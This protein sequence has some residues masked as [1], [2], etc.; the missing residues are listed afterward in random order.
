MIK[1]KE[2]D[3]NALQRPGKASDS[4]QNEKDNKSSVLLKLEQNKNK[5]EA[6]Q[7]DNDQALQHK[8]KE[9]IKIER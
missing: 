7:A 6:G 5:L 2:K 8:E 1:A 3:L 4:I 9:Q